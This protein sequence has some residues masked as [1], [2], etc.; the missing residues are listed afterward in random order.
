MRFHSRH[1][2]RP[3]L[4]FFDDILKVANEES[5]F[6]VDIFGHISN[7]RPRVSGTVYVNG[8]FTQS[9]D[10]HLEFC[11]VPKKIKNTVEPIRETTLTEKL[12]FK[13]WMKDLKSEC[14]DLNCDVSELF[15]ESDLNWLTPRY[16]N[17]Q[18]PATSLYKHTHTNRKY[19]ISSQEASNHSSAEENNSNHV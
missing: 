8:F 5:F 17:P 2:S 7:Y 9:F 14:R 10:L 4:M 6:L 18:T 19:P 15:S 11:L 1:I 16:L 3:Y 12:S 13:I